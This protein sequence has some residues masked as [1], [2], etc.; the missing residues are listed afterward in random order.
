MVAAT[1][2]NFGPPRGAAA[3]RIS[4]RVGT[5]SIADPRYG[6]TALFGCFKRGVP[7]LPVP[8]NG[9]FDYQS[10]MGD[11]KNETWHLYKEG[12]QVTPDAVDGFYNA[13]GRV[14]QLWLTRIELPYMRSA[15]M[16]LKNSLGAPALEITAANP[17]R[18]GGRARKIANTPLIYATSRT[19][20]IVAEKV[21]ANEFEGAIVKFGDGTEREYQ[22]VANT[23]SSP[24]ANEVVF[25]VAAQF[26]LILD[27]ITGPTT[28]SGTASYN[29][30]R[31]LPGTASHNSTKPLP[32]T[33]VVNDRVLTGTGTR[34]SRDLVVGRNV[35]LDGEARV[36]DSITSDTT[37]TITEPFINAPMGA[38]FEIDNFS[39]VGV[40][41]NFMSTLSV[42]TSIFV[43][44]D[45]K[46][47]SRTVS[48]VLSNVLFEV[49]SGFSGTFTT[50]VLQ[51]TNDIVTG[52][53]S[54]YVSE[55]QPGAS[56]LVDP[57]RSGS[58]VKVLQ[59]IDSTSV[60]IEGLFSRDFVDA[61][62]TKQSTTGEVTLAQEGS[63][64][65]SVEIGA[66][67]KNPTTH[68]SLL[69]RFNGSEVYSVGDASLDP[70]DPYFVESLINDDG[71]NVLYK[72][73]SKNHQKWL[74]VRNLWTSSY[75]TAETSDVRP[76]NGNEK[77]LALTKTRIYTVGDFDYDLLLNR[78]LFP[79][80]YK[81]ARSSVRV[82][83][84]QAPVKLSGTVSSLGTVVTGTDSQFRK[85]VKPGDYLYDER[86]KEARR[87]RV[88]NSNSVLTL[89]AAFDTNMSA[90]SNG[91][92]CGFIECSQGYDLTQMTELGNRF[93]VT[94]PQ[95]L[96]QGYDGNLAGIIPY[97]YTR[98]FDPDS[99]ILENAAWGK[100][101]GLIKM[102]CPGISDIVVQKAA[103][104]YAEFVSY[105]FRAEIPSNYM[106][107]AI[108]EQ[109]VNS[110]LGRSDFQTVSFPSYAF[111]SSPLSNGERLISISGDQLGCESAR[112]NIAAG[113][114]RPYAGIDAKL[115]R[116]TRLPIDIQPQGEA[117]LNLAGITCV[118]ELWGNVVVWGARATAL[119]PMYD[120]AHVRRIQSNYVR[121]FLESRQLLAQL[122]KPNQPEELDQVIMILDNW[123][124]SERNKGVFTQYLTFE[125]SVEIAA[126][127]T[128]SGL[129]TDAN[130]AVGLVGVL[131]GKLQI[132]ISYIPTGVIENLEINISPDIIVSKYGQ[133]LTSV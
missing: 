104:N 97:D 50:S 117:L 22:I 30:Y 53:E 116:I 100:N 83:K 132:Y 73:G 115:S 91:I 122:F 107:E 42:G 123:A 37:A 85:E 38:A 52:L 23:R 70:T 12:A 60:R 14:G 21:E 109:F 46:R 11:P 19:F 71:R 75:T 126:A 34:F 98:Y 41:T 103:V 77:I 9:L 40:G 102:A 120:F 3:V 129:I 47:E 72:T 94:Y 64:G 36:I 13:G 26:N 86:T 113:Y 29:R 69:V 130:S 27:G 95:Y 4:E 131:N 111:I 43:M 59:V 88:V 112:A 119:D 84:T 24:G 56:Y 1:I 108:A 65:L 82:Q 68:F 48:A 127:N 61:K 89:D 101:L 106:N 79:N 33:V 81:V 62:L 6:V 7:G 8:F 31:D 128:G 125:Q 55:L 20:T 80:P 25:T 96:S 76:T 63:D 44:I 39:V 35:Y 10:G 58:A 57:N 118:K 93:Q 17:G 74:T 15:S 2:R 90:L 78:I 16:V 66:G 114:H 54:A 67:V 18:W 87:V 45:G 124:R 28:L 49:D 133:T 92:L 32:G 99:S 105:E 5:N 51:V 121:L 110:E